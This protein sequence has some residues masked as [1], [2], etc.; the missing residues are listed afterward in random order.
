MGFA[1]LNSR[2]SLFS[3][4]CF[5]T[6][7]SCS[8]CKWLPWFF[9]LQSYPSNFL[10]KFCPYMNIM[11]YYKE[12]TIFQCSSFLFSSY[13]LIFNLSWR[14]PL[15]HTE[16]SMEF[17][18]NLEVSNVCTE[19][20]SFLLVPYIF[21]HQVSFLVFVLIQRFTRFSWKSLSTSSLLIKINKW[22]C[23]EI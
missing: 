13:S 19:F 3:P 23:L 11:G 22:H 14:L 21:H 10:T 20:K 8:F 7:N 2:Y 12:T 15:S 6:W 16:L 18:D 4:Q 5:Q 17:I 1:L 9:S